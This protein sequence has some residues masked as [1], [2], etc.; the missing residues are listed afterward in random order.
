MPVNGEDGQVVLQGKSSNDD[1]GKGDGYPLLAQGAGE[2]AC[3]YPEGFA[4]FQVGN[5]L[6]RME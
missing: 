5:G 3:L 6:Q 2:P 4:H 1:V